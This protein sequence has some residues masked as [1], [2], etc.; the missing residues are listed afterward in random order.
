MKKELRPGEVVKGTPFGYPGG[1]HVVVESILRMAPEH[2]TYCEPFAGGG[3]V[4]WRHPGAE[5]FVLGDKDPETVAVWKA[6]KDGS[7]FKQIKKAGCI[8]T[9]PEALQRIVDAPPSPL[10]SVLLWRM[11]HLGIRTAKTGES[12]IAPDG[13]RRHKR[14]HV[15]KRLR[16]QKCVTWTHLM[17]R[18]EKM[19]A[20]TKR[21]EIRFQD[22]SKTVD[23]ADSPSTFFFVD[24]PWLGIDKSFY[25]KT[26]YS[27]KKLVGK[28]AD[29][30][31]K[32]VIYHTW[33]DPLVKEAQ[34]QRANGK[35]LHIYHVKVRN[36]HIKNIPDNKAGY[37]LITN[38]PIKLKRG[39]ALGRGR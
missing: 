35:N 36:S 4:F 11:S 24:P 9:T 28:M 38:Y 7:L 23:E 12:A 10:R 13:S 22:W 16:E 37:V 5:R 17:N 34:A 19:Q 3:A 2:K 21:A 25:G 8:G 30:K 32:F 1:S 20:K 27:P 33:H 31:G 6:I 39:G 29:V 14:A 15:R 26:G 18:A